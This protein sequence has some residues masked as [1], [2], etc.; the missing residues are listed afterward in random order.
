MAPET[1]NSHPC[2]ITKQTYNHKQCMH[3]CVDNPSTILHKYDEARALLLEL[4]CVVN[5]IYASCILDT[6]A[7]RKDIALPEQKQWDFFGN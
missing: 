3:K 2:Q 4:Y 6:D 7:T 1:S 5:K